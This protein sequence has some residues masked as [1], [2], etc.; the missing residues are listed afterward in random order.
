MGPDYCTQLFSAALKHKECTLVFYMLILIPLDN[1]LRLQGLLVLIDSIEIGVGSAVIEGNVC[2]LYQKK[3]C[4]HPFLRF[5]D[6]TN[7][8]SLY[9]KGHLNKNLVSNSVRSF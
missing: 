4:K 1:G 3:L 6:K 8:L 9:D 2:F 5:G 7:F